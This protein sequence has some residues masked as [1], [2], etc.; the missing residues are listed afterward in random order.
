MRLKFGS[1]FQKRK[2]S[3]FCDFFDFVNG[4]IQGR[5]QRGFPTGQPIWDPKFL[6][7]INTKLKI[8]SNFA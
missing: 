5:T 1:N 6:S 4:F 2:K 3:F 7:Q 8:L